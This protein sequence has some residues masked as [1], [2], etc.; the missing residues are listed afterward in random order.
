MAYTHRWLNRTR[1]QVNRLEDRLQPGSLLLGGLDLAAVENVLPRPEQDS[2]DHEI[3]KVTHQTNEDTAVVASA[4]TSE[5]V[6]SRATVTASQPMQPGSPIDP[7]PITPSN[8]APA[9]PARTVVNPAFRA[10]GIGRRGHEPSDHRTA[11]WLPAIGRQFQSAD[12]NCLGPSPIRS[13]TCTR[14]EG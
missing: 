12:A 6:F 14:G 13:R 2:S 7:D 5:I 4:E 9:R 1:I 8:A 10:G 11:E 3:R